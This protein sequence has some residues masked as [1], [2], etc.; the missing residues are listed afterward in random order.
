MNK[1]LKKI[2]EEKINLFNMM[3]QRLKNEERKYELIQS[4]INRDKTFGE[5]INY[6]KYIFE[7]LW[8][9][10]YT[11]SEILTYSKISDIR[12]YL[13]HFFTINFYE[14]NLTNN[15]QE[16]Q[17]LYIITLQLKKELSQ[18][19][20]GNNEINH[21]EQTFLN[22]TP[23]GFIFNEL[24]HKK[25]IQ[26][27]FK[28][29]ILDLIEELE[30]SYPSQEIVFNPSLIRDLILLE[31]RERREAKKSGKEIIQKDESV[32]I[33]GKSNLRKDINIIEKLNLFNTKYQFG[34]QKEQLNKMINDYKDINMINYIKQKIVECENN[35]FLYSTSVLLESI[36]F[37]K[38]SNN[39]G[40][41]YND[42]ERREFSKN[43]FTIYQQS[44]F[45]TT[46]ILDKLFDKLNSNIHLL[47]NIIKY[48]NKII[49]SIIDKIYPNL[50]AF[51]KNVFVSQF[52]LINYFFLCY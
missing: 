2:C 21:I 32:I 46:K 22:N 33:F 38:M 50:S 12:N 16:G 49:F 8:K 30:L 31:Q 51:E 34:I 52:F 10:P 3:M 41:N 15:S 37:T 18:I 29:I 44:F 28:P 9:N 17:L 20:N 43:V 45:E 27:F 13:A 23:C 35:P 4:E 48:I 36:N 5:L 40:E 42:E 11:V 7:Y 47:P 14:N 6:I 24:F 19:N 25:E 1:E 26:S 39:I